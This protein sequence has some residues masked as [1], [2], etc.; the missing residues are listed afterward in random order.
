M[1]LQLTA[2]VFSSAELVL[3]IASAAATILG[4]IAWA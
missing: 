4:T 2:L 3:D 1:A